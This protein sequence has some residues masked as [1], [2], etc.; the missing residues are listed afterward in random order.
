MAS[1]SIALAAAIL[2]FA[3]G[4]IAACMS[5]LLFKRNRIQPQKAT[6][7]VALATA[8]W[9]MLFLLASQIYLFAGMSLGLAYVLQVIMYG[10]MISAVTFLFMFA[11]KA[12]FAGKTRIYV[13][14]IILGII[15]VVILGATDSS[16][17]EPFPDSIGGDYPAIILK[18]EHG[19]IL[20]AYVLPTLVGIA[21]SAFKVAS[22]LED[23]L[24]SR[25]FQVIGLGL[26]ISLITILCDTVATLVISSTIGYAIALYAQW[27][28]NVFA[29]AF[30]YV[31]W[32]MPGWFQRIYGGKARNA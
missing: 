28:L 18:T 26:V 20:A 32:T 3:A 5:A 4:V 24:Y 30:L 14:Y 11:R 9:S 23:R 1:S 16:Y 13:V 2:A 15:L 10:S 17:V 31:G 29:A 7:Y 25:G 8:S 19:L 6:I 12:F 22:R 21:V 27:V